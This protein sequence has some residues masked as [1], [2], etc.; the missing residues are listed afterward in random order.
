MAKKNRPAPRAAVGIIGGSGVYSMSCIADP[1][2]VKLK[3]PFGDPSGPLLLGEVKGVACAFVPRHGPGHVLLPGEIPARANIWA[4]K[5]L[6]VERVIAISAVGSLKEELPPRHFVFP[7]QL[8]D[9][10]KARVSTFFGD[11][12]VAHVAF[13]RPFCEEAA[14]A[15]HQVSSALGIPSHKG[16]TYVCMEGPVFSTKAESESHRALGASLIGMTALPEAKLAREAELCYAMAALVTD[17]DCWKE[18][19]EVTSEKVVENLHANVANAQRLLESAIPAVAALPRECRCGSALA[20]A[21]FSNPKKMR[22]A[23]VKK[24]DLLIGKYL[25]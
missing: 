4:L 1:R 20:G 10:T 8:I 23:T 14:R 21:L 17:Y 11:G 13:D 9:R 6:G 5:S 19:E 16:G 2:E 3:T 12:V 25:K 18:G 7:D 24:L 15:L 22:P